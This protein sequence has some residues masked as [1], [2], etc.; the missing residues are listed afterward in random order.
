MD[1]PKLLRAW[2]DASDLSQKAVAE[3]LG[4][5][6]STVAEWEA[7][8]RRPEMHTALAL[9][10]R[11]AGAVQIEAWDYDGGLID[12]ARRVITRRDTPTADALDVAPAP[13]LPAV[14]S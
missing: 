2:R 1:G 9:E 12:A 6:Q 8:N 11:S 3:A 4:L 13:S 7:G 10:E 5:K 14:A